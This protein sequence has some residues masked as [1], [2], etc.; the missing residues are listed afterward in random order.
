[1]RVCKICKK[2]YSLKQFY[3][4]KELKGV[5]RKECK[6]CFRKKEH[7]RFN[8]F[9]NEIKKDKRKYSQLIRKRR[10]HYFK[11]K[12]QLDYNELEEMLKKQDKKCDICLKKINLKTCKVDHCHKKGHVR[13]LLCNSCNLSLGGFKDNVEVLKRAIRYLRK[14]V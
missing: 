1:M 2:E 8:N 7:T 14:H 12:Y 10:I 4:R 11:T 6:K 9:L 13:G 5:Y 3:R